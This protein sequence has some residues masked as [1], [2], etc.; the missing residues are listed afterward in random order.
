MYLLNMNQR[1]LAVR[2]GTD[3]VP[4]LGQRRD[5]NPANVYL[6]SLARGSRRAMA[7]CLETIA[8]LV[9]GGRIEAES[10]PWA[11]LRYQHTQAVRAELLEKLA[12]ATVNKHAAALRGVLR[13]AFRLGLMTAEDHARA[14][15]LKRVPGSVLPRGRALTQGEIRRLFQNLADDPTPAGARD[16]ALL[17]V[18]YGGGVRRAEAIGLDL[19]D[20]VQETGALSVRGGKGRKDRVVYATNG[21]RQALKAWLKERGESPGPLFPPVLKGGRIENRRMTAQAVYLMLRKRAEEAGVSEFSP[22][23]LRRSF[24]SDLLDAGADL[25]T[26]QKLAGHSSVTTTARYDRRGEEVK[27]KAAEMLHVPFGI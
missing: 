23:D 9:S 2:A 11:Q 7:T 17:A 20:W 21:A 25:V 14:S 6:K 26:V 13:E 19:A 22:H 24:I 16:A 1:I 8:R 12:P 4:V 5:Q 3:L 27:R 10:F 18:L 15:D